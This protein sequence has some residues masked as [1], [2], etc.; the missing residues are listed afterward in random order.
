LADLIQHLLL[1]VLALE[2]SQEV[3]VQGHIKFDV[4]VHHMQ[5]L[6]VKVALQNLLM[7]DLGMILC[8]KHTEAAI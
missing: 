8:P 5:Y 2:L 3:N 4:L 7:L 6:C 1:D